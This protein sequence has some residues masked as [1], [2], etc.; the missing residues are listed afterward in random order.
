M[1]LAE[2]ITYEAFILIA[3]CAV[4]FAVWLRRD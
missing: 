4:Q 2:V 3:Y 1:T